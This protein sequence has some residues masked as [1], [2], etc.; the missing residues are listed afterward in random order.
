MKIERRQMI[1]QLA[2]AAAGITLSKLAFADANYSHNM[3]MHHAAISVINAGVGGN[4]TVDLL[5]RIDQDC[6]AH[7][8]KLTILMVGT[9]DMNSLK[10]I[11]LEKYK[12]NVIE[13]ITKIKAIGSKVLIMTIL[14]PY[15]AYLL[16]RHAAAFYQPEGVAARR[17]QVNE[18]IIEI[19]KKQKI[20]LL[21]MGYRFEA[22]GKIGL[23]KESLIQNEAN[24]NKT[25]G[26][27]PTPNGYRFMGLA[28]YD[29]VI[30]NK[31]PISNIVCFGDSITKGDGTIDKESYPAYLLK[32]LSN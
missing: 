9:N 7:N 26:I 8:P 3:N 19:A 18:A 12:V 6:L 28:V 22:I 32:L 15:E 31:L 11:P 2:A 17:K 13:I 25:D 14:P 29:F 10:Y 16:T 21:D 1:K 5:A 24:T 27:H 4:N 20:Y 30:D 23:D